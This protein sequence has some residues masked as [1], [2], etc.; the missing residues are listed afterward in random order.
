MGYR[1]MATDFED[2]IAGLFGGG[3]VG[4][5]TIN[6]TNLPP[7]PQ[8]TTPA[9]TATQQAATPK[10]A[11]TDVANPFTSIPQLRQ[12]QN[13]ALDRTKNADAILQ[14]AIST[15]D[16]NQ[17]ARLSDTKDMVQAKQAVAATTA[18]Q[19]SAFSTAVQPILQRRVAIAN[20]QAEMAAM[21]P[22]QRALLSTFSLGHNTDWL[23][24][25]DEAAK[26]QLAA[27]GNSYQTLMGINDEVLKSIQSKFDN[28]DATRTLSDED[29]K[30]NSTLGMQSAAS[31]NQVIGTEMQGIED[32]TNVLKAQ[33]VS[34]QN[35]LG[36]MTH[37]QINQAIQQAQG[38]NGVAQVNGV[39]LRLGEL[40]ERGNAWQEQEYNLQARSLAVQSGKIELANAAEE[41][42]ISHMGGPQLQGIMANGGKMPDGTQLNMEQLTRAYTANRTREQYVAD[43]AAQQGNTPVYQA[44][45]GT[46]GNA[47]TQTTKRANDMFGQAP[48]SLVQLNQGLATRLQAMTAGMKALPAGDEQARQAYIQQQLPQIQDMQDRIMK[49]SQDLATRW[50]GGDKD[51]T[52]FAYSQLTGTPLNGQ[53]GTRALV[54]MA[55]GNIPAG[56]KLSG[57]AAATLETVKQVVSNYD[58]NGAAGESLT[59]M[60]QRHDAYKKGIVT[61][62]LVSLVSSAVNKDY[63]NNA[64]NQAIS[65]A[66][67][68][69]GTIQGPDGQPH[70]AS[71][72]NPRDLA[73]AQQAGSKNAYTML[74]QQTPGADATQ[75]EKILSGGPGGKDWTS[76]A[77]SHKNVTY[78]QVAQQFKS[79]EAQQTLQALDQTASATPGFRPSAAFVDL[80]QNPQFQQKAVGLGQAQAQQSP[81]DNAIYNMAGG[82]SSQKFYDYA[83]LMSKSQRAADSATLRQN[84][85]VAQ[86]MRNINP[87]DAAMITLNA[88]P[89]INSGEARQLLAAVKQRAAP[90]QDGLYNGMPP[91]DAID[92]VITKQKFNDPNLEKIRQVAAT[93]WSDLR[94]NIYQGI[95]G[96]LQMVHDFG[97][98][99]L[100]GTTAQA[101]PDAHNLPGVQ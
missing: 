50:G 45:L 75:W 5:P 19:T 92:N 38:N 59:A 81:G 48:P 23:A 64:V 69:A 85:G 34:R 42:A 32:N 24:Q 12:D 70:P 90:N 39:P 2:T 57:P 73:I 3:L 7:T 82:G 89:G 67:Q 20:R 26:G 54:K 41:R 71:K 63:T 80:L 87:D 96:W 28:S 66:P 21:N 53:T 65:L 1:K 4:G 77:S 8:A 83:N 25:Q 98:R 13:T 55:R 6:S 35:V 100:Y 94:P 76:F 47:I 40:Q 78:G 22:F 46:L 68:I 56:M 27:Q 29:A 33:E 49:S 91:A 97:G 58:Q 31:A 51:L 30:I 95:Q 72:I 43:Q 17:S 14:S 79:L 101:F 11:A 62:E 74:A 93:H 10:A 60:S 86:K 16:S 44:M 52:D 61:P 18:D 15:I 84:L 99:N 37:S 88:I 9:P 36:S